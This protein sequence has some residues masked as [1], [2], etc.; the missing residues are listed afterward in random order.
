VKADDGT[1]RRCF[2]EGSAGAGHVAS[3]LSSASSF[4][5]MNYGVRGGNKLPRSQVPPA[6]L[7]W[8]SWLGS[9]PDQPFNPM[10]FRTW[11]QFW[12]FGGGD[13]ADLMTIAETD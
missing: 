6:D 3:S 8:K 9:A 2:L 7:D 5:F 11:R 12:D 1:T 10:K 13:L 4:W